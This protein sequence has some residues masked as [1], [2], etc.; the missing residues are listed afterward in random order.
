MRVG[1]ST[2]KKFYIREA[3][4]NIHNIRSLASRR[5]YGFDCT[6]IQKQTGNFEIDRRERQL[7]NF[8]GISLKF[9]VRNVTGP[10]PAGEPIVFNFAVIS[11]KNNAVY[12]NLLTDGVYDMRQIAQDGT[13]R[14]Y[15]TSRDTNFARSGADDS[16]GHSSIFLNNAHISTDQYNVHCHKKYILLPADTS[17]AWSKSGNTFRTITDYCKVKRQLRYND[18][19]AVTCETPIVVIYWFNKLMEDQGSLPENSVVEMQQFHVGYF[20]D[21]RS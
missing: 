8:R 12:N 4:S 13:F 5:L 16:T 20:R 7:V 19:T 11:F 9:Q 3:P 2:A 18:D 1:L 10:A 14:E 15:T 17:N 6:N 21:P